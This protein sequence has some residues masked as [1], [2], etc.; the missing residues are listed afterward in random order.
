MSK[1]LRPIHDLIACDLCERTILKGERID[2][3]VVAGERRRV[4]ELC[5]FR[6]VRARWPRESALE[7]RTPDREHS[8]PR[9]SVWAKA[10]QWAEE[11]GLW[12]APRERPE[13]RPEPAARV[14]RAPVEEQGR[15]GAPGPPPEPTP[16]DASSV[17]SAGRR[18][19]DAFEASNGG[20]RSEADADVDE[21]AAGV[22]TTSG[23]RRS[24]RAN[25]GAPLRDMLPGRRREPRAV[26]AVPASREGKLELALELFNASEHRRTITGIG[27]ALGAPWVSAVT[28]GDATAAR[29]VAIVVAWEL[30]WYRYRVDLDDG[31]EAV[32]LLDR[33]DEVGDLEE[34][35][36][37]WNAE[38][39]AEGRLGLALESVS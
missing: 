37:T 25:G 19:A 34:H 2:T 30:S 15:R 16:D 32:M 5:T 39:D 6:A 28:L 7:D 14:A 12:A 20:R 18:S 29:E 35:L 23:A 1:E 13:S 3:F 10:A 24:V 36:R 21:T 17:G 27:R 4:C 33:G 26:R 31:E 9:R 38:A 11:Q 22:D 8:R